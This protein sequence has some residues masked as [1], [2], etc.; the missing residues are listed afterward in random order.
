[1]R[2]SRL[3]LVLAAAAVGALALAGL[4]F[5][6]P[7]GGILLSIVVAILVFLSSATWAALHTRARVVRGV[8]IAAIG[9]LAVLKLAGK[10]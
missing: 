2:S 4:I 8:V 6:G 10:A 1:V 9:G 5:D 7:V 3:T